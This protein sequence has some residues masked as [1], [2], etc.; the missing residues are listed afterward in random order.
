MKYL[1][2][3]YEVDAIQWLGVNFYEIK[4]K[5][6]DNF[7]LEDEKLFIKNG[8]DWVDVNVG[9]YIT[10]DNNRYSALS[11]EDFYNLYQKT[12]EDNERWAYSLDGTNYNSELFDTKEQAIEDAKRIYKDEPVIVIWVGKAVEPELKWNIDGEHFIENIIDNLED[13]VGEWSECFSYTAEE[14]RGLTEMINEA[15]KKWIEKYNI[16]PNCYNI[17]GATKVWL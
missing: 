12:D 6:G 14:E 9:D 17:E 5:G 3:P 10:C 1:R 16:K 4:E 2:K 11:Y 7:K 15:V 8:D 13:D